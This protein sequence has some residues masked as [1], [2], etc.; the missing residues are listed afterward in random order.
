MATELSVDKV[1]GANCA[2]IRGRLDATGADSIDLRLTAALTSSGQPAI[3]DLSGVDFVASMGLRLL[4][5]VAK[6]LRV[7]G[8]AVALFGA[9]EAVGDVLEQIALGEL[10][11][12]VATEQE[13]LDAVTR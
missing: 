2:R 1:G 8:A 5:S 6:A 13:A 12:I 10:M 11:P 7:K 9:N 3:I 4:I